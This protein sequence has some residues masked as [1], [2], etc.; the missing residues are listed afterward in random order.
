MIQKGKKVTSILVESF[1]KLFKL[2]P[3]SLPD[4]MKE[5]IKSSIQSITQQDA[6]LNKLQEYV[7]YIHSDDINISFLGLSQCKKLLS[8]TQLTRDLD[9]II[10]IVL[11]TN[12]ELKLFE[13]AKN[14]SVQLLKYQALAIIC[15]FACGTQNQI[16]N[17]LDNDR[18]DVLFQTINSEYDEIIGLGVYTLTNISSNNIY[19]RDLLLE[20]GVVQQFISLATKC[21]G[22]KLETFRI[23]L[24]AISKF[25]NI[26][27][28]IQMHI[29]DLIKFLSEII[30]AVDEEQQLIDACWGL[31]YLSQNDNQIHLLV[32][33]G[34][35][36]KLVMLLHLENKNIVIP[37]LRILGN[38]LTGTE[39]Q[40]DQVLNA[41]VLQGFIIQLQQSNNQAIR[42]DICWAL[43]NIA[44]GTVTQIKQIITKDSL[45]LSL[46]RELEIGVP[47]IVQEI[48]HFL[49]NIV[50]YADIDDLDHL[51]RSYGLI[52]QISMILDSIDKNVEV[53][54]EG[55]F[56]FIQRII[57]VGRFQAYY[58]YFEESKLIEK[59]EYLQIHQSSTIY[60]KCSEIFEIFI[61]KKKIWEQ[62]L[63]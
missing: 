23:I 11:R 8:N 58:Q 44:A 41:G 56:Q 60:Q 47:K 25:A 30:I 31:G 50:I 34:V 28:M 61:S 51:V 27:P 42:Q 3:E 59:V 63:I 7:S 43:S 40:T 16:Q 14:N 29:E 53:I 54:L 22:E 55:I 35:I 12:I 33:F 17:I 21:K 6:D 57:Q 4:E 62:H 45:L 20:K 5:R 13:I 37:A 48:A 10:D 52:L 1:E 2:I 9:A 19:F 15:S 18:V 46:F 49:S 38:I 36:E 26:K 24:W 32:K 39:E